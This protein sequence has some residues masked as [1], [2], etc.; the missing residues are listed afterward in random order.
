[1]LGCKRN[2]SRVI[3]APSATFCETAS[4]T[5]RLSPRV[6]CSRR[7]W[8]V[9]SPNILLLSE[10]FRRSHPPTREESLPNSAALISVEAFPAG[11]GCCSRVQQF[12]AERVRS[13][14]PYTAAVTRW[15]E[16]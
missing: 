11:K 9:S 8:L 1:M 2:L 6:A 13:Q 12:V 16:N 5:G 10:L 15:P 3:P 7:A 14:E 4:C